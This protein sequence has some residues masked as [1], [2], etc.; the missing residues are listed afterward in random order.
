MEPIYGVITIALLLYIIY[1]MEK[2]P[3]DA[4]KVQRSFRDV[5]P[6]FIGKRCEITLKEPL[7]IDMLFSVKGILADVD[8]EWVMLEVQGKKKTVIK[9]FR[10]DNISGINEIV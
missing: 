4:G 10:I 7:V 5:L 1:S 6:E 3:E 8:D 9:I 2:E